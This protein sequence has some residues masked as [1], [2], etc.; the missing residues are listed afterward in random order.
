LRRLALPAVAL[1]AVF[2]VA[3]CGGASPTPSP[4]SGPAATDAAPPPAATDPPETAAAV[5]APS[6]DDATVQASISDFTFSPDPVEASVGDVIAW[7]N[8]DPV[9]HSVVV[10]AGCRTENLRDGQAGSLVF[11]AAGTYPYVCGIHS[12]M[13]GTIEISE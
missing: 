4:T 12:N 6:T 8:A 9:P 13:T 7:T 3:A 1:V 11:T 5:C 10:A 2:A